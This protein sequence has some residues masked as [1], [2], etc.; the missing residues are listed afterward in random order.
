[1]STST[2]M[3]P[4][5]KLHDRTPLFIRILKLIIPIITISLLLTT[6]YLFHLIH[7]DIES[8]ETNSVDGVAFL[9][10]MGLADLL[11]QKYDKM[12]TNKGQREAM[13]LG[14][15]KGG[16]EENFIKSVKEIGRAISVEEQN[17]FNGAKA[18]IT[19]TTTVPTSK[20]ITSPISHAKG[21]NDGDGKR[22]ETITETSVTKLT[23]QQLQHR[24]INGNLL[25]S[26]IPLERTARGFS[27]MPPNQTPALVGARRGHINCKD[28][29]P[30]VES[31]ISSMLAFWND[32]VGTR[33]YNAGLPNV[34]SHPFIMPPL[35][36]EEAK[37]PKISRR[38]YLTFET[39]AGGWN[40]IRM[41]FENTVV[42]AAA[43][44]RT[45]VL[46]PEQTMYLL[47][48]TLGK[49]NSRKERGLFDYYNFNMDLQ[50]RV[51]IIS[52]EEF[53][54]LEGGEDGFISLK[55]YNST[56]QEHLREVAKGPCENRRLADKY[57]GTLYDH[58]E[59]KG[60]WLNV[61][62]E[63]PHKVC[64]IFDIGVYTHGEGHISKLSPE[65]VDRINKFCKEGVEDRPPFYYTKDIHDAKVVHLKTIAKRWR[66]LAHPHSLIFFT[67]PKVGNYYKRFIRDFLRYRDE[68][69]CAAGKIILALQYEDYVL[70]GLFAESDK[71]KSFS[72]NLDSELVG[73]YSSMHIRRGDLQF[74]EVKF[75]SNEWYQNT[76]EL[77]KSNEI[78]Y[79]ATDES[80][81]TFF[82]D[83]RA[84]HKGPLRFF[85]DYKVLAD[86]DNIDPTQY[87]MI[88]TIVA[89]RGS[90]FAGTWF[91]TFSGYIF[92]LRG[93]YGMSKF[94]SYYSWLDRKYA[95]QSWA[96]VGY[97]SVYAREYPVG[98]T[99][100]DSDVFID[101]DNEEKRT[102]FM[103]RNEMDKLKASAESK[104]IHNSDG[105]SSMSENDEIE[106]AMVRASI[107]EQ[108]RAIKKTGVIMEADKKSLEMTGKLQDETRKLL[109]LR[110][111][112]FGNKNYR[113]E[114][115]LEF[116]PSIPDFSDKGK[117]GSIVVEL[118]PISLLPCSVYNFLE[119]A[120]TWKSG[121][122]HRNAGHVLQALARSDVTASMPFQEY[123]K[124]Y[125]HK[126]GTMGYA[127]RPSGPEFYISIEDNSEN[128]GP[129][130][131]Q[132][133]N[134]Y[135]AD[136]IIGTVIKG[137]EDGTVARVH[138]MPGREFLSNKKDWVLIKS[139]TILVPRGNGSD[140]YVE[141][142]RSP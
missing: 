59:Q 74:K 107:E 89:S 93:Y 66:L 18:S 136:S 3:S 129:G 69:Y 13:E 48:S 114:L 128:H 65:I 61:T 44:G 63:W 2:A 4:P 119:I 19:K 71:S 57:C 117:A 27:G 15:W 97:A 135:E 16:N 83:F 100:I 64:F 14:G 49:N 99:G 67:D 32:P 92:R 20:S 140:G 43:M 9:H 81:Q 37:T 118:A 138:K 62:T 111:G 105:Q 31:V 103:D 40:N 127:G 126:K 12:Q 98:W 54:Q 82:D 25:P 85:D 116:Q 121:A 70:N 134:K 122:F 142:S 77:W 28:T 120:R 1:M 113:V 53:L 95:M 23:W 39:D 109:K 46:P 106:V 22:A 45:V 42:L 36:M 86:I 50:R 55:E 29:H 17:E 96:D 91:S 125:P 87:G 58:Y 73:G 101:D 104:L 84:M 94:Y 24:L 26:A 108:V 131:Q 133:E 30:A 76:K 80:N 5:P 41:S 38:R 79:I 78:L 115:S 75:D 47:S 34:I 90:V 8:S 112:D 137:M 139:M 35:S 10:K 88:E 141:F 6:V 124:E 110:Y 60:R 123:S 7:N 11:I 132:D 130:S 21:I 51:P 68:M 72:L 52:A 56:Y 102:G 33:D